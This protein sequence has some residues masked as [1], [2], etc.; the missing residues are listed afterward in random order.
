MCT[1]GEPTFPDPSSDGI[2]IVSD[3]Q[4]NAGGGS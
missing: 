4:I 3:S 1:H 2:V